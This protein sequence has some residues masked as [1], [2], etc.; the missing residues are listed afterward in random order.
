MPWGLSPPMPIMFPFRA[1][2]GT[3]SSCDPGRTLW[4]VSLKVR[5]CFCPFKASGLW[6]ESRDGLLLLQ[7][8]L[9]EEDDAGQERMLG[10]ALLLHASL[11]G[12]GG[13]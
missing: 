11:K 5:V 13:V 1:L 4:C 8:C 7:H 3:S 9:G 10:K 6:Q 2:N 12:L